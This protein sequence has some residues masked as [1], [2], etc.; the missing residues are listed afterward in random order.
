MRCGPTGD[1]LKIWLYVVTGAAVGAWVSPLVYNAAKAVGEVGSVKQTNPAFK[2][3]AQVCGQAE[4]PAFFKASVLLAVIVLSIPFADWIRGGRFARDGKILRL[5]VPYPDPDAGGVRRNPS[6][7]LQAAAGFG[8]I[9]ALLVAPAILPS[10]PPHGFILPETPGW[11]LATFGVAV[12]VAVI[13]EVLFRGVAMGIFLRAMGPAAAILLSAVLF[14]GFHFI[15]PPAGMGVSNPELPGANIELVRKIIAQFLQPD[16]L[17]NRLAPLFALGCL[18]GWARWR[19][20]SLF[21]S[22]G[23]HAAWLFAGGVAAYLVKPEP[24]PATL[25]IASDSPYSGPVA[26]AILLATGFLM[27]LL[28]RRHAAAPTP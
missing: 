18:L 25:W 4:F 19:T 13:R 3:L 10:G 5:L 22:I 2:W 14:A 16:A 9:S 1:V 6:G 11:L 26:L 7:I 17:L 21:L 24:R 12:A 20:G 23:L 28:F 8:A 15:Q 27:H